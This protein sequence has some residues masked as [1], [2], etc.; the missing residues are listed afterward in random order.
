MR[1]LH[2]RGDA[3][4]LHDALASMSASVLAYRGLTSVRDPL[5]EALRRRSE[6]LPA[7]A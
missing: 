3:T 1:P 6:A 4:R 7:T 2:T 5:L